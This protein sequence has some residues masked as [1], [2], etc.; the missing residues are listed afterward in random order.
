[1]DAG[2]ASGVLRSAA[3]NAVSA[4]AFADRLDSDVGPIVSERSLGC[5]RSDR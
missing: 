3:A 2:E 5:E 4:L 1:M